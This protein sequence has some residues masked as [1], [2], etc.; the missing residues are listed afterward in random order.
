MSGLRVT[1]L[2]AALAGCAAGGFTAAFCRGQCQLVELPA[3]GLA[4]TNYFVHRVGTWDPD[5]DGPLPENLVAIGAFEQAGANAC[6]GA[7]MFDGASWLPMRAGL[8]PLHY[9]MHAEVTQ[10][11]DD[12]VVAG[13]FAESGGV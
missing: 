5:G 1:L 3:Y 6:L 12:F 13:S 4:G 2:R 7:A 11:G 8:A 10:F 9:G